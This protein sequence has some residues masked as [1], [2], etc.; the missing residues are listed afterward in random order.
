MTATSLRAPYFGVE[1]GSDTE[2]NNEILI[3]EVSSCLMR[4]WIKCYQGYGGH[5]YSESQKSILVLLKEYWNCI[6]GANCQMQVGLF[7]SVFE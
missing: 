1:I 2:D 7:D 3:R 4:N 5:Y 6:W